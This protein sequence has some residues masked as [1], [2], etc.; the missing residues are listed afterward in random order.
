MF[1]IVKQHRGHVAVYSEKGRGS[2]FRIYFPQTEAPAESI[3]ET[4]ALHMTDRGGETILVVE[5]EEFVRSYACEVLDSLGYVTVAAED[6]EEAIAIS[7]SHSGPIHLLLTDV[8]LPVMDGRSLFNRLHPQR[9]QMRVL[10][11]SGYTDEAIVHHGVLDSSVHFIQKPFSV[12]G[13]AKKLSEVFG[14]S[15]RTPVQDSSFG[16]AA[17]TNMD[18][19]EIVKRLSGLP[20]PL[21]QELSRAALE[22]NMSRAAKAV[23]R[24]RELDEALAVPLKS[25]LDRFRF[26]KIV[27]LTEKEVLSE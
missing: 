18:E 1:G 19:D 12:N 5:D 26:D 11:M 2:T 27:G 7:E 16:G 22:A 21:L 6:P 14:I 24:I 3:P 25:W 4:A 20:K 13:L 15:E 10:Y 8:V 9:P 23:E 17:S